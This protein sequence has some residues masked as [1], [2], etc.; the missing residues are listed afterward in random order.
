LAYDIG[1]TAKSE[2][3]DAI[4][5]T[6][7][8]L[9]ML[10]GERSK[11]FA[12]IFGVAFACFLIAEQSAIFCGVMLRTT[13]QIR[14]TFGADIWVMNSNLRYVD[15]L[16]PISDNDVF[17]VRGVAGVAWA[18]NLYRGQTQALLANGDYQGLILMGIDDATLAGAPVQMI[19]GKLGDLQI[20]DAILVDEAG[21][22]QMWPGEPLQLGKHVHMNDRAVVVG[23]FRGSR[24]FMTMPVVYT[25]FSQATLFVPPSRRLMP[26]VLAKCQ[27]GLTP[28]EVCRRI[29]AQTGLKALSKPGLELLTMTYYLKHTGIPINF[30]TTVLLAF[31]V[32]CA[33]AG[34]TFYLFTVENL[35]Q[36]GALKAMGMSDRAVVGMILTQGLV[37]GG[38]GYG[39]GIGLATVFGIFLQRAMPLLA[40][41]LPWQVVVLTGVLIL[42]IVVLCS[43]LCIRRALVVEPAIVFQG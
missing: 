10:M 6:R 22:Q 24:T 2:P 28:E 39:L 32:G 9:K 7:I 42:V 17:R 3:K 27:P 35:K 25:R 18:V 38:I 26:F 29:E 8:A 31:L 30:G 1:V 13:G 12:I 41:F 11:Y 5:M 33:I 34:Q 15:D 20:A 36:F 40:F 14:D 16:K 4:T 37:V 43:L 23:I 21:F 19:L